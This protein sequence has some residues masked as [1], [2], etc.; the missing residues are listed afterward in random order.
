M[1]RVKAP[2]A[3]DLHYISIS[4]INSGKGR[5]ST[6]LEIGGAAQNTSIADMVNIE[7]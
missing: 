4:K 2:A 5:Y 1:E 6:Y 7:G 3:R